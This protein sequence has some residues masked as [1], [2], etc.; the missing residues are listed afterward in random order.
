MTNIRLFFTD[1]DDTLCPVGQTLPQENQVMLRELSRA[2]I[3]T[4]VVTGR[5]LY[6]YRLSGI[7]PFGVK[8]FIFST[9]AGT[10]V[11][12][13]EEFLPLITNHMQ[14]GDVAA[15]GE[16]LAGRNL[17]FYLQKSM[18]DN[19]HGL[20][21]Q[22]GAGHEDFH[23]RSALYEQFLQPIKGLDGL[24]GEFTQIVVIMDESELGI[25]QEIQE[26]FPLLSVIRATSPIDKR[27]VWLEIFAPSVSKG[28]A[29]RK[30]ADYLG[31]SMAQTA[32]VGN[33]YND[34]D[35]LHEAG[36]SFVTEDAPV[37]MVRL[38]ENVPSSQKAGF[39][40][41]AKKLLGL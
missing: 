2:G 28:W 37:Q 6:S 18:P 32:A 30:L 29:A 13:G 26:K 40:Y 4:V 17:D 38:F 34:L 8:Y 22:A 35:M 16:F 12:S 27:S 1:L 14:I 11:K 39:A 36:R 23:R 31:V 19:H 33:D 9:G 25:V 21:F 10:F 7:E 3:E 15:V 5:S 20:Y 24:S 41:A